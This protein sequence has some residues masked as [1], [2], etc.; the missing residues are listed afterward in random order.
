MWDNQ[1]VSLILV[2]EILLETVLT[3]IIFSNS[4]KFNYSYFYL[5]EKFQSWLSPTYEQKMSKKIS[6]YEIA[7]FNEK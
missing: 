6:S 3:N 2:L 1:M 5:N 7:Q 4:E